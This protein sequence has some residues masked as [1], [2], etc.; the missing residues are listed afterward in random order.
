MRAK[1]RT[2]QEHIQEIPNKLDRFNALHTLRNH[3]Y[4]LIK[5]IKKGKLYG[6]FYY[7]NKIGIRR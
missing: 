5:M 6:R 3:I 1:R 2:E 4:D 7:K